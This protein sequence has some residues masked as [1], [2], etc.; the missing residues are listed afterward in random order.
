MVARK[1]VGPE[2]IQPQALTGVYHCADGQ[3]PQHRR[4][5]VLPD[6]FAVKLVAGIDLL[7]IAIRIVS[8][9]GIERSQ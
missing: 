9:P 6:C 3:R 4:A 5:V 8:Y 1:K 7:R 2:G